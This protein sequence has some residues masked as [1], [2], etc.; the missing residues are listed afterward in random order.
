MFSD[1]QERTG[2]VLNN[3]YFSPN[4]IRSEVIKSKRVTQKRLINHM[5]IKI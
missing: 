4:V 5:G 2:V 3:L 1:R